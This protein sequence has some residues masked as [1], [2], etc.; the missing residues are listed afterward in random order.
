MW[1]R[2]HASTVCRMNQRNRGN[3]RNQMNY[4]DEEYYNNEYDVYNMEYSNDSYEG[5]GYTDDE[6][7]MNEVNY[8]EENDMYEM[9][10][11]GQ[12]RYDMY[13]V[14][15]RRSERNKDRVM[16]EERDRRTQMLWE[17][18]KRTPIEWENQQQKAQN[19]KRQGFTEEQRR[20]G[21]ETRKRNN[22]CGNCGQ[23]G[24]FTNNCT[25]QK[26]RLTHKIPNVKEFEPVQGFMESNVPIQWGQYLNENPSARKKLRNGLKY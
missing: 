8:E 25:N 16:N 13:P 24:H 3:N 17:R 26:V 22:I 6:Y 15:P 12:E 21:Q 9:N 19:V 20:K 5:N 2:G 10:Y 1:E 18:N 11:E 23:Q 14:P 4:I 7:D